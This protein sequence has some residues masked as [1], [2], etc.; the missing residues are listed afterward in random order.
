MK[1]FKKIRADYNYFKDPNINLAFNA[2]QSL[3]SGG[4]KN[5]LER[6]TGTH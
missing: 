1:I 6:I 5:F 2:F 4:N 3:Q